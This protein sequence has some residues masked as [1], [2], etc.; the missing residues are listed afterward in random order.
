VS[1]SGRPRPTH[2]RG[3]AGELGLRDR[4]HRPR[5]TPNATRTEVVGR[6]I[7]L[8]QQGQRLRMSLLS[9]GGIRA[10]RARWSPGGSGEQQQATCRT[11]SL[12]R[13]E[14]FP[15]GRM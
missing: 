10:G 1:V 14:L 6:I 2:L 8:R 5:I 4:S 7:Y 3:P 15:R 9:V 12:R 11:V 13:A